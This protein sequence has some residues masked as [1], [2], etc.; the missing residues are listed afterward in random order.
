VAGLA[1]VGCREAG[2]PRASPGPSPRAA[3]WPAWPRAP[4]RCRPERATALP[5]EREGG[6]EGGSEGEREDERTWQE[7]EDEDRDRDKMWRDRV[8]GGGYL[9][10]VVAAEKFSTGRSLRPVLNDDNII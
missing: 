9:R 2:R 7:N 5:E 4:P 6:K 3:G 1:P 10:R 8:S